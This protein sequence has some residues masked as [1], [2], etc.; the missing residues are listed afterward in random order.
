MFSSS[1]YP[2]LSRFFFQGHL[3]SELSV[4]HYEQ[5]SAWHHD[6]RGEGR[7]VLG[8]KVVGVQVEHA[9]HEGHEH[10]DEDHHELEDVFDRAPQ[11]DLQRAKTLV[12]W[13]NVG[14]A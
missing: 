1:K 2:D 12:G 10:H 4:F 6:L 8:S 5:H 7:I 11:G 3:R 14:D 9:D 13:Q